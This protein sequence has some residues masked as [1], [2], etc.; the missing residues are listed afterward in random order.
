MFDVLADFRSI[1][2]D[3]TSIELEIA[4]IDTIEVADGHYKL[5]WT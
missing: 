1:V 5:V 2:V 3:L 4:K